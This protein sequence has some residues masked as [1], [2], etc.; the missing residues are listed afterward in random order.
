MQQ[1]LPYAGRLKTCAKVR[2]NI[3]MSKRGL[4]NF[5]LF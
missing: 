2:R 1:V 4:I 5:V 3:E